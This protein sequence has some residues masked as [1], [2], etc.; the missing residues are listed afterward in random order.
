MSVWPPP[1]DLESIR[2]LVR[3][4]DPEGH[5]AEGSPVDEYDPEEEEIFAAIAELPTAQLIPDNLIPIIERVWGESFAHDEASL[6]LSRPALRSLAA[7]IARF[8]GPEAQPQ[9]RT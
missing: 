9:V 7:Q 1:P 8:F 5:L 2:E 4:A 6:A 3:G